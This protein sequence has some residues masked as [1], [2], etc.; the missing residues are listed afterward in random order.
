[1]QVRLRGWGRDL[2]WR[3]LMSKDLS[4]IK[5]TDAEAARFYPVE[6]EELWKSENNDNEVVQ[7]CLYKKVRVSL[8]G[9]Y[10]LEIAFTASDII[11]MTWAIFRR[12]ALYAFASALGQFES[13]PPLA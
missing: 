3:N 2:G 7:I 11:Y 4:E 6:N 12:K 9:D 5:V 8:N 1:M 13:E 10:I